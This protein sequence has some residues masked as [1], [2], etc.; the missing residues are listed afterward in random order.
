MIEALQFN[1]VFNLVSD[2]FCIPI[3]ILIFSL[4]ELPRYW[5]FL[6][7]LGCVILSHLFTVIESFWY[8]EY[9]DIAEHFMLLIAGVFFFMGIVK[10]FFF[11]CDNDNDNDSINN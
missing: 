1:E 2:V 10:Y 5:L 8:P 9:F 6:T 3:L 7:A 4:R 11:S